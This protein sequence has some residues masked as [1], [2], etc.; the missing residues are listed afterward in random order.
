MW[1]VASARLPALARF[2][3]SDHLKGTAGEQARR[4]TGGMGRQTPR[5]SNGGASVLADTVR[6][7]VQEAVG[8]RESSARYIPYS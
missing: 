2:R 8:V 5:G 3:S 6:D 4:A 7:I 1:P